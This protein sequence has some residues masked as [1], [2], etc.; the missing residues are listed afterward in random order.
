MEATFCRRIIISGQGKYPSD[1][2]CI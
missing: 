2:L 1:R